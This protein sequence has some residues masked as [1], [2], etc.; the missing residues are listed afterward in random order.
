MNGPLV[1]QGNVEME[2]DADRV[3]LHPTPSYCLQASG[4]TQGKAREWSEL[5][6]CLGC[7]EQCLLQ[8]W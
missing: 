5:R 2:T 7:R 3:V 8:I 4:D 6:R 1:L